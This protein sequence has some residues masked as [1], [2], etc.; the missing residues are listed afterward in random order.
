MYPSKGS[1]TQTSERQSLQTSIAGDG[2]RSSSVQASPRAFFAWGLLDLYSTKQT[3]PD[4]P[5]LRFEL[6]AL[7]WQASLGIAHF[8]AFLFDSSFSCLTVNAINSFFTIELP[9]KGRPWTKT[10]LQRAP[11]AHITTLRPSASCDSV[12]KVW[13]NAHHHKSR[14]PTR[15]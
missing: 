4:L 6:T 10:H 11:V 5:V 7:F 12:R 9:L 1:V 14:R 3:L 2:M 8:T 15:A 13:L